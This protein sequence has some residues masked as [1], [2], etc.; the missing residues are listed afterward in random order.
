MTPARKRSPGTW[1]I[2]GTQPVGGHHLADAVTARVR[3]PATPQ[4]APLSPGTA[5]KP[6]C[7]T[8]VWQADIT[9]W[10]LA[11]GVDVEILDIIDDHSRLLHRQPPPAPVFKAGAVVTDLHRRNR[12]PRP[13]RTAAH[14]QRCRL[15]RPLPRPRLGRPRTHPRRPRHRVS[16]HSQ[17]YHPQT[18]G[19]VERFHQTLKKWLANQPPPPPCRAADPARHLRRLLQ[20]HRPHRGIDRRTPATAWTARPR[21]TPT[22]QGIHQRTLPRPQRP[23]R[24]R[25]QTHPAPRQPAAPHRHRPTPTPAPA[26]SCSSANSTSASSPK[27]PANSSAN[28]NSTPPATTNP[29][30]ATATPAGAPRPPGCQ[31]CPETGVNDVSRTGLSEF[32]CAGSG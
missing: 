31:L 14:R 22:R 10:P 17:P 2:A 3:H 20:H 13:A 21:A 25:R 8:S 11:N 15:H 6:T 27:T 24:Q 32:L 4:T 1:P 26:S 7:P 19:K 29:A 9:H 16:V 30:A 5:S 12:P 23:R 28:S 18:C